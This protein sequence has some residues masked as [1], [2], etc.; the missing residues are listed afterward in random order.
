MTRPSLAAFTDVIPAWEEAATAGSLRIRFPTYGAALNFRQRCYTYRTR[1]REQLASHVGLV[2]NF[3]P[4]SP[5]D[6]F[7]I[8]LQDPL[9]E[10]VA[11]K[12]GRPAAYYD[13]IIRRREMPGEIIRD[14]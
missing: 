1:Q 8:E 14:E 2:D 9:G 3:I 10:I 13:I 12:P 7:T 5:Y 4:E 11:R 6:T